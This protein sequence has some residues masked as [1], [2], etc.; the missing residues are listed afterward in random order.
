MPAASA[1]AVTISTLRVIRTTPCKWVSPRESL[2]TIR[3]FSVMR[4]P[5]SIYTIEVAVIK[6]IPPSWIRMSMTICPN[7]ENAV[8]ISSTESPVTHTAD[9]AEKN[10]DKK[11]TD[12]PVEEAA[13]R[14]KRMVPMTII[15]PKPNTSISAG[16]NGLFR[17]R[18]R[19]LNTS[20]Q[21][22]VPLYTLSRK[23]TPNSKEAIKN[24][25]KIYNIWN[26][27]QLS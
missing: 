1:A 9:V 2:M 4:R 25:E 6:P 8:P 14:H 17:F 12:S 22:S 26:I 11:P 7:R 24:C 27:F 19:N 20:H 3:S 13:G 15:P 18:M 23:C 16:F 5:I 10:A 21:I